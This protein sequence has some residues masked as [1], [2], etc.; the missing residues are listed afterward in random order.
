M[1][2]NTFVFRLFDHERKSSYS[3]NVI[4][5]DGGGNILSSSAVVTI[6][7]EDKNDNAPIFTQYPYKKNLA[8][9]TSTNVYV[10]EV[11]ANDADSGNNG[12]VKYRLIQDN[13][14]YFRLDQQTG[15]IFTN[16]DLPTDKVLYNLIVIAEDSGSIAL[17]STGT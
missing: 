8:S 10:T 4:A 11:T 13:T 16:M 3:F 9:G 14:N 17:S 1:Y 15:K 7:I 5:K 2:H 12:L 6:G